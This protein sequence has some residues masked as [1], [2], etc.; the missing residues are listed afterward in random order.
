MTHTTTAPD[1]DPLALVRF[2][3][4]AARRVLD[5]GCG[6]GT[7]A[8][9]LRARGIPEL[10]C[11]PA[12]GVEAAPPD[13]CTRCFT[14]DALTP[15]LPSDLGRFD[16]IFCDDTLARLRDPEPLLA[17]LRDVLRPGGL[18]IATAPNVQHHENVIMLVQGRWTQGTQG[19]L[20]RQHLR[21]F[22]AVELVRLFERCGFAQVKC[23]PLRADPPEA[24]P[25]DAEGCVRRG[26]ICIGPLDD[27]AYRAWL[28]RDY[29]VLA[30]H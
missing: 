22:T 4:A 7:R 24:F 19:A 30:S 8:R 16:V 15:V 29:V 18:M 1:G 11:A 2:V 6:D 13:A 9:A 23:T 3:P 10:V 25:R 20:A 17:A 28:A 5:C 14:L 26:R 12:P 27:R 21:F